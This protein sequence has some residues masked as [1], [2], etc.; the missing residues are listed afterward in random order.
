MRLTAS[1]VVSTTLLLFI[2][3]PLV[4]AWVPAPYAVLHRRLSSK[5]TRAVLAA[6]RSPIT[7][8]ELKKTS[9]FSLPA[10]AANKETTG[11]GEFLEKTADPLTTEEGAGMSP[12]LMGAGAVAAFVTVIAGIST[13]TNMDIRYVLYMVMTCTHGLS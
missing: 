9:F 12:K 4:A 5:S 1:A 10:W 7:E 2:W 6:K 13:A 11:Q 3:L 8:T